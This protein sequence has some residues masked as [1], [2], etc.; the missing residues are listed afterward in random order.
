[1]QTWWT[2]GVWG[3]KGVGKK[4]QKQ[5]LSLELGTNCSEEGRDES[6]L[7]RY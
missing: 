4:G 2:E 5:K 7:H 6:I 3:L 1:M